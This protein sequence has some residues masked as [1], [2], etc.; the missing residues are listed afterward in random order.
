MCLRN[1]LAGWIICVF[2]AGVVFGQA[3]TAKMPAIEGSVDVSPVWSG[4]R[5]GFFL[6]TQGKRQYAAFYDEQRRM[7]VAMRKLGSKQ[8]E[9]HRPGQ[10]IGWDSHNYVTLAIDDGGYV[11]LSGNMHGDPLVYFR[12]TRPY[13]IGSFE[14]VGQ[15]VGRQEN[16]CTY[17]KFFRGASGE[18]IFTYRDGGSGNGNQIYNVYDVKARTWRRLLESPLTDGQGKMN[19]YI[20]GPVRGPDGLFHICWV[21]RDT[22]DCCTNHDLSYAR[23]GDMVHWETVSG[24]AITL[25][26]TI[27]T[28][29][30]VVDAVPVKGGMVNGNTKIGFD[31]KGRVIVSYHKF[32]PNGKTQIYNARFGGGRWR[33]YQTSDWDYRWY[34]QGGG[35]IHFEVRVLGVVAGEDGS[36]RQSYSHDKY[37]SGT[38]VLD[39]K[40]LRPVRKERRASR[41]PAELNKAES[42]FP[43]MQV[44]FQKDAG[45]SGEPG[46]EYVLRWETLGAN[47]DRSREKVPEPSMLKVYKLRREGK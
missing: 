12:T 19:A 32:D 44:R 36:L 5:V 2:A 1:V 20:N 33:I 18:L 47:R 28:G 15:M 29:G 46:V 21:W 41:W 11:H 34:F 35:T 6:L 26:M 30:I 37:G 43:G 14:R 23:S 16:R 3:G 9:Y 25:P 27:E 13:D 42:H 24:Q 4:H 10:K 40:T 39:E 38:W 17:P 45:E 22:P 7:T 31:S 8:W